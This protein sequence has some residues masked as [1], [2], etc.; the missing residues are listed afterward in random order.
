MAGPI[1]STTLA[2]APPEPIEPTVIASAAFS[3]QSGS[4]SDAECVEFGA[5][6]I[7]VGPW[8]RQATDVSRRGALA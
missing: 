2:A 7:D 1:D 4:L 5:E 8:G 6:A 3:T